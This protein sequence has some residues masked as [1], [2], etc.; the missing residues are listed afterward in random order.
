MVLRLGRQGS[1]AA[2]FEFE[3]GRSRMPTGRTE[4]ADGIDG[5]QPGSAV[6]TPDAVPELG[7]DCVANIGPRERR[8]RL[9]AGVVQLGIGLAALA[10]LV[11]TGAARRWRLPLLLAFWGAAAGLFQ[12]RDKT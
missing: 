3:Q 10:A 1:R 11:A 7:E 9:A 4:Y 12:W 6:P 2:G 8:K 5:A